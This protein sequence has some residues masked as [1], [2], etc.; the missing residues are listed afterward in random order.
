[1]SEIG[2][3]DKEIR[4]YNLLSDLRQSLQ[5]GATLTPAK[6]DVPLVEELLSEIRVPSE[7]GASREWGEWLAHWRRE[8]RL[9]PR[10]A[11]DIRE[12]MDILAAVSDD[13][14]L[15]VARAM[16]DCVLGAPTR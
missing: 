14:A 2:C 15:R 11:R 16:L 5:A 7:F 6:E 3:G 12:V 9:D 8:Q 13:S 4:K 10:G 1:M